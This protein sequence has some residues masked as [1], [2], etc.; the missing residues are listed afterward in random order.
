MLVEDPPSWTYNISIELRQIFKKIL[1]LPAITS[2]GFLYTRRRDG[3]LGLPGLAH[4]LT[5]AYLWAS[6]VL[7]RMKDPILKS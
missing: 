3:G 5:L 7:C 4:L 2:M 6:A 1:H